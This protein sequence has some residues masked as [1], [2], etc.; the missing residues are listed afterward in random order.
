LDEVPPVNDIDKT[1][2]NIVVFDDF[3]IDKDQ[4]IIKEFFIRARKQN[5]TLIYL[6]QGYKVVPKEVRDQIGYVA[7]FKPS[8]GY[9]ITNLARNYGTDLEPKEF[10]KLVNE[11]T[12]NRGDF[13]FI[14]INEPEK[15]KKYRYNLEYET[16]WSE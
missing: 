6:S 11:T 13:L 4:S 8:G 5:C 9:E 3:A 15:E 10:K 14:D 12:K 16:N 1:E 2:Q 7:M